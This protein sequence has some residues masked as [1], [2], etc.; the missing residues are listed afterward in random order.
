MNKLCKFEPKWVCLVCKF[1]A[2][3]YLSWIVIIILFQE[4]AWKGEFLSALVK[5]THDEIFVFSKIWAK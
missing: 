3:F 1:G 2:I 4:W 5:N